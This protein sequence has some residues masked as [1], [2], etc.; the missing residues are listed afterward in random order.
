MFGWFRK[1][2]QPSEP[3]QPPSEIELSRDNIHLWP[4]YQR[5]LDE[6][7]VVFD[8]EGKLRYQH[9]APVGRM[10]L[11]RLNK[12]GTPIYKESAREWFDPDSQRA[13]EFVWP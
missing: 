6:G 8:R 2:P 4:T 5:L 9:G 11:V 12:D 10:I 13:R 1:A 3:S 7:K